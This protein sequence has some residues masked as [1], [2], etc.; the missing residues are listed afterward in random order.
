LDLKEE[1][2]TNEFEKTGNTWIKGK[3]KKE[4]RSFL[5][6]NDKGLSSGD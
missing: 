6:M 1:K 5:E 4:N 2:A 3:R